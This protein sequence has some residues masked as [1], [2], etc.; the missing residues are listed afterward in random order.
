VGTAFDECRKQ[1]GE[2]FKNNKE[3]EIRI[4]DLTSRPEAELLAEHSDKIRANSQAIDEELTNA[5]NPESEKAEILSRTLK[6]VDALNR[7]IGVELRIRNAVLAW[8]DNLGLQ[9]SNYPELLKKIGASIEIGADIATPTW[10]RW[11]SVWH[12]FGIVVIDEVRGLGRDLKALVEKWEKDARANSNLQGS[13]QAIQDAS[14]KASDIQGAEDKA[15]NNSES[16]HTVRRR[17]LIDMARRDH[18]SVKLR[19]SAIDE[20]VTAYDRHGD[21]FQLLAERARNDPNQSVRRY[22]I[23]AIGKLRAKDHDYAQVLDSLMDVYKH[24]RLSSIGTLIMKQ[25]KLNISARHRNERVRSF[26]NDVIL[27]D[28]AAD[29]KNLAIDAIRDNFSNDNE[30]ISCILQ[31]AR[32]DKDLYVR[33]HALNSMSHEFGY[34]TKAQDVVFDILR[35]DPVRMVRFAALKTIER[36]RDYWPNTDRFLQGLLH[37]TND[38]QFRNAIKRVLNRVDDSEDTD[39]ESEIDELKK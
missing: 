16:A 10:N 6:D 26:L 35:R 39:A 7:L 25:I 18:A 37:Q 24:E 12:K 9:I 11:H 38:R 33:C 34:D 30:C 3:P 15:P 2:Q 28:G 32:E 20:L 31:A 29:Q 36:V 1:A 4:A 22:C 14:S 8:L 5:K 27:S 17:V 19:Q 21:T 13:E 23:S